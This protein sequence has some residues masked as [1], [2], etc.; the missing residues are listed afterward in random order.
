M[1]D[2]LFNI[3]K[4]FVVEHES[5]WD[6]EILCVLIPGSGDLDID[7]SIGLNKISKDISAGLIRNNIACARYSKHQILKSYPNITSYKEEYVD[8]VL[9][10]IR[11]LQ[12][13]YP[14]SNIVLIGHSLG[15]HV[16]S[17]IA[18]RSLK[19]KAVIMLNS[20]FTSMT[21]IAKWQLRKSLGMPKNTF[22]VMNEA[23]EVAESKQNI[24]S[25]NPMVEYFRNALFYHP[26]SFL[27][28]LDCAFMIV[29][30]TLDYQIPINERFKIQKFLVAAN[31]KHFM[32]QYENLNHLLIESTLQDP[33][34]IIEKGS[35]SEN[36][37][38]DMV[39]FIKL[40]R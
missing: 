35:V 1:K 14:I 17:E 39:N 40:L 29:N 9:K 38:S 34:N 19:V 6:K 3:N 7:G 31:I 21:E 20:H 13:C 33:Y 4:D 36:V 37:I 11:Q 26:E 24:L 30:S 16:A 27:S 5:N 12:S 28:K 15:G 10:L 22:D 32:V 18:A 23:I 8:P 25:R 2:G